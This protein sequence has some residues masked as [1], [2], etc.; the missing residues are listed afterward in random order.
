MKTRKYGKY[1]KYAENEI[2]RKWKTFL[3]AQL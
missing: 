1:V 3:D 2:V